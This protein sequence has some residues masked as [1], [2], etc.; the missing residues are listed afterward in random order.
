MTVTLWVII[1]AD[2]NLRP[3]PRVY[4]TKDRAVAACK[5]EGDSVVQ[6]RVNMDK[7]PVFILGGFEPFEDGKWRTK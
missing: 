5:R 1:Q 6:A 7:E 2:G 4:T 3:N